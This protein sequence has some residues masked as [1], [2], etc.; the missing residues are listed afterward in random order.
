MSH[1][2]L[3]CHGFWHLNNPPKNSNHV[4]H[5]VIIVNIAML[6]LYYS[7]MSHVTPILYYHAFMLNIAHL[8]NVTCT[9]VTTCMILG[10]LECTQSLWVKN[11][12]HRLSIMDEILNLK[13]K[14]QQIK[15]KWSTCYNNRRIVHLKWVLNWN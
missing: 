10:G 14:F 7:I 5:I 13:I 1:F 15:I 11:V 6:T 4:Y 9:L 8:L 3:T 12:S 2:P